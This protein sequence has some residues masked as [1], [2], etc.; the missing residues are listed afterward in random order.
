MAQKEIITMTKEEL[1]RYEIIKRLIQKEINGTEAAKQIDVSTRQVR[2]MK[3]AVKKHGEKGIIHGHRGQPGNRKIS[4]EKKQKIEQKVQERYHDFGPTF[5]AEKL[6][7]ECAIKIGKET[8]RQW[9]IVWGLWTPKM[10]KKNKEYRAWRQRKDQEG[11]M[12]QF[13]GSYHHWFEDRGP[14]CCLL[15]SIDDA[16][17]KIIKLRFA[18]W[19]RVI[20][21]F[22]FWRQYVVNKGKP[23]SIYL[24]KHSTYKQNQKSVFDD[25]NALTQFGRAMKDLNIQLIHA[26]SAPAKGRVER[27]NGT[28]QDRLV[29]EL[30]LANISTIEKANQF[31]EKTFIPK[32]NQKFARVPQKKGN[33][34]QQ[35][36]KWESNNLEKI[37][38]IQKARVVANDFTVR[39]KGKYFQLLQ[40][41][42]RLVLRKD[43]VLIEERTNGQTF[44]SL[45]DK[46]LNYKLLPARPKKVS[47]VKRITALTRKKTTWKPPADHP[48]RRGYQHI[49]N[50]H[51]VPRY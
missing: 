3:A 2:R 5:A 15:V 9:M 4:E 13:D 46:Y 11:E 31:V 33:L 30:R 37:F 7:E 19:E 17:G 20:S 22:V 21:V 48:W 35:L 18:D 16:T 32:F 1:A 34:H 39:Y 27:L 29:K 38:S 41:Q 23:V 26:H 40:G 43:R 49:P 28:L 25:P 44:I 8:L 6:D 45:K 10:R 47:K 42:P 36:I 14:Y 51:Y 12:I 50:K 24:D